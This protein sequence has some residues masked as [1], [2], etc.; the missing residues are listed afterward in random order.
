MHGQERLTSYP[1]HFNVNNIDRIITVSPYMYELFHKSFGL[2]RYKFKIINNLVDTDSL[3]QPKINKDIQFNLGIAGILPKLKQPDKAIR[4][5]EEL[6]ETDKRYKLF[7]KSRKPQDLPWLMSRPD[8]QRYYDELEK[9]IQSSPAR[10]NIIFDPHGDDMPEWFRKIGF[11]LST[12]EFESF[13]LTPMEGM[14]AGTVPVI[15][16][17]PGSRTVHDPRFVFETTEEAVKFI[18][19]KES[20]LF[21]GSEEIK[22]YA[23]NKCGRIEV[24]NQIEKALL[25]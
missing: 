15:L 4:I 11:I 5:L 25:N 14:A 6:Y 18:L 10:D 21:I 13:H 7:I 3:N 1:L 16:N 20:Q 12:S 22:R 9:R 2:P 19:S 23:V 8:E 24:I 17:W